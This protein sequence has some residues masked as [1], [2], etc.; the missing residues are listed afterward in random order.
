M[1]I[2]PCGKIIAYADIGKVTEIM[3]GK[4]NTGV[5]GMQPLLLYPIIFACHFN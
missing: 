3:F 5:A 2:A 1:E 4:S